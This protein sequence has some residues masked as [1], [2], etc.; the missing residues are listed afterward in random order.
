MEAGAVRDP[1]ISFTVQFTGSIN[2]LK[3]EAYLLDHVGGVGIFEMVIS[4][5]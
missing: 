3:A 1:C 4:T 5:E 2:A